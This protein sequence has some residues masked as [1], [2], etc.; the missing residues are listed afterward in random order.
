MESVTFQVTSPALQDVRVVLD[1]PK[2]TTSVDIVL[3]RL[4]EVSERL[5]RPRFDVL[6]PV[7]GNLT[8]Q[9]TRCDHHV[10]LGLT[11]DLVHRRAGT[12]LGCR[13]EELMGDEHVAVPGHG[14]VDQSRPRSGNPFRVVRV[15]ILSTDVE[16]SPK[17]V[18]H[19]AERQEKALLP[20]HGPLRPQD[21]LKEGGACLGASDMEKDATWHSSMVERRPACKS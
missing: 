20:G 1:E 18:G 8:D 11:L 10:H 21:V 4:H 16:G 17:V 19:R 12:V 7:R 15:R 3:H 6:L 13:R 2:P 14:L 9:V 5:G